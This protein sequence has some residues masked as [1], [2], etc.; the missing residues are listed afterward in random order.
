MSRHLEIQR[1][2]DPPWYNEFHIEIKDNILTYI[3]TKT[4]LLS[5]KRQMLEQ[6][7]I[8]RGAAWCCLFL[9]LAVELACSYEAPDYCQDTSCSLEGAY[10]WWADDRSTGLEIKVPSEEE[11]AACS[12]LTGVTCTTGSVRCTVNSDEECLRYILCPPCEEGIFSRAPVTIATDIDP[13]RDVSCSCHYCLPGDGPSPPTGDDPP[14]ITSSSEN[15][16]VAT[17]D[18]ESASRKI[19]WINGASSSPYADPCTP[20]NYDNFRYWRQIAVQSGEECGLACYNDE[21]CWTAFFNPDSSS[22][23]G[24]NCWLIREKSFIDKTFTR[25]TAPGRARFQTFIL[26]PNTQPDPCTN[27]VLDLVETCN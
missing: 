8:V 19:C 24:D 3:R 13:S 18:G 10:C 6:K 27:D 12:A 14:P 17:K 4:Y 21:D 7:N 5:C 25:S 9:V 16:V 20:P 22:S 1:H 23:D 15:S 2:G 11:L 26:Y